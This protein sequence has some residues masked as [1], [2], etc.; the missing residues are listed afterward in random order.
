MDRLIQFGCLLAVAV[1]SG[2]SGAAAESLSRPALT[3]MVYNYAAVRSD[4][5]RAA[6]ES[7]T[8]VYA[9]AG[10]DIVWIEPLS[11]GENV[12]GTESVTFRKVYGTGDD[13]AEAQLG[14]RVEHRFGDGRCSPG[15]QLQR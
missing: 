15:R 12:G 5:V 7:V 4:W 2:S 9:D 11:R 8:R 14:T 1:V 3:V 13:S 10:V 6:R